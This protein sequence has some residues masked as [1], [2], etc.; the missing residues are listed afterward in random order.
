MLKEELLKKGFNHNKITSN[1]E[2]IAAVISIVAENKSDVD[3]AE[4]YYA[5]AKAERAKAQTFEFTARDELYKA[6]TMKEAAKR[7]H[8][9]AEEHNRSALEILEEAHKIAERFEKIETAEARD[10]IR[11]A[12]AFQDM[13]DRKTCYDNTAYINGLAKILGEK[14]KDE[15]E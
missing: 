14:E 8:D 3:A 13:T 10:R 4:I 7:Y 12:K 6:K 2:L 9:S 5:A 15:K 1:F 11:L